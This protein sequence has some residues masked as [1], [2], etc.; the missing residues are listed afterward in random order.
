MKRLKIFI[1]II[2]IL[3]VILFLI[4]SFVLKEEKDENEEGRNLQ[5]I[6]PNTNA[7][8]VTNRNDFY[9]IERCINRYLNYLSMNDEES[10]MQI[11][12]ETYKK[13]NSITQSNVMSQLKK[14]E[15]DVIFKAKKM[16][17]KENSLEEKEYY[18][19]GKIREDN[20][21]ERGEEKDFTITVKT[22]IDTYSIIPDCNYFNNE[23]EGNDE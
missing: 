8:L 21:N 20:I 7:V 17:V 5:V 4:A 3:I 6:E 10:I 16:Y 12:D 13:D 18:V 9:T 2:L 14:Q 11:L 15:G 19:Y 1:I 22:N 23:E